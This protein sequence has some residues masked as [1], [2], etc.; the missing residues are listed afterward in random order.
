VPLQSNWDFS[1]GPA[2]A[3]R[4]LLNVQP[5]IPFSLTAEWNLITR[6]IVPFIHAESPVAWGST[7]SGLGDILQSFFFSPSKPI[8]GWILGAGPVFLYPSATDKALG[9][10]KWGAGPPL[11]S[12]IA[13][14]E[15]N[16]PIQSN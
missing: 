7:R 8:N 2:H 14:P 10:E 3:M 16:R 5:V 6:T 15:M 13:V 11:R 12:D 9:G 1:I 4:Y